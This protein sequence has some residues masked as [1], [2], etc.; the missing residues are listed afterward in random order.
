MVEGKFGCGIGFWVIGLYWGG[1]GG[2]G[3]GEVN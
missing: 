1:K 3:E 2:V